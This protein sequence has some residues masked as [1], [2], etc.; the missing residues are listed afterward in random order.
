[1]RGSRLMKFQRFRLGLILL[2]AAGTNLALSGC[3]YKELQAPCARD[4][5]SAMSYADVPATPE[6]F[7]SMDRCGAM[8]PLNKGPLKAGALDHDLTGVADGGLHRGE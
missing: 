6:P 1:M 4:E 5:G 3:A 2:L 7:A 8:R